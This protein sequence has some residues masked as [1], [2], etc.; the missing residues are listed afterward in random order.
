MSAY[1]ETR[2]SGMR[3]DGSEQLAVVEVFTEPTD[4][5]ESLQSDQPETTLAEDL[6][7]LEVEADRLE[8]LHSELRDQLVG[9]D[10]PK[11]Q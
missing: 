5:G 3:A 2:R 6:D 10:Q 9:Q 4:G 1:G 7:N 8:E 11:H